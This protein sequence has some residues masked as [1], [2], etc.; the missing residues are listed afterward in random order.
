[1]ADK[2]VTV[3]LEC[4]DNA[5][6]KIEQTG[7]AIDK[8][9]KSAK[10]IDVSS[11]SKASS[12][13]SDLAKW[14][15]AVKFDGLAKV[16]SFASEAAASL[17]KSNSSAE[18][19]AR[20]IAELIKA[21]QLLY[22]ASKQSFVDGL[23]GILNVTGS[24]IDGIVG[25]GRGFLDLTRH[26]TGS[27]V[28]FKGLAKSALDY[29]QC[30]KRIEVKSGTT[31]VKIQELDDTI[32]NI[33]LNTTYST[34]EIAA[35]A[36][37]M[38]QNGQKVTE[39]IDNLYAVTS[40]ATLGNIDLAKSG[41]IVAT[42]MNMFR[43]QSLTATQAANMFAYAANHSGANV[44][45]LA[46]SLENCGPSAA[47]LNVPFSE[48]MAVLGAVGDNAIKSGK[49]GT[50]LKNLLQNMSAPTKNTAKCI[51]ELGLE[52][53]QTAITSGHLID[54]L[55]LIKERLNDGTL[56]AGQQNAAIKALAGAWGSQGLGAV[57]NGSEVELRAMARAMEDGKDST[58]ALEL[59]SGKL[60]DTLEGK[61]YKFSASMEVLAIRIER[62]FQGTFIGIIDHVNDFV[63]IL[64][65]KGPAEAIKWVAQESALHMKDME[66]AV[67]K[68]LENI[69]RLVSDGGMLENILLAGTNIIKS[70]CNGI[71]QAAA[72]GTLQGIVDG[73]IKNICT[74]INNNLPDV[75]EAAKLII[76]AIIK[77][78]KNNE[79]GIREAIGNIG[80]LITTFAGGKAN[81][82]AEF[83]N[84]ADVLMTKFAEK[85][86]EVGIAKVKESIKSIFGGEQTLENSFGGGNP[87]GNAFNPKEG[88]KEILK[89][90]GLTHG[91]VYAAEVGD[92]IEGKQP[93]VTATQ[94]QNDKLQGLMKQYGLTNGTLYIDEVDG[95]LKTGGGKVIATA[96]EIADVSASDIQSALES[97][98]VGQLQA[99]NDA[100]ETLGQTT[101]DTAMDMETAFQRITDS[102]R[103]QFL[104]LANIVRNQ[105]LNVSNIVRNQMVNCSN[106]FR[107]QFVN[108]TNIAK[109][110]MTNV[111]NNIRTSM[112]NACNIVR[113]QCVN[114]T[115]IVKNQFT[116][117][118]NT[119]R[120]QF[121]NMTNIAR[122]QFVNMA[123]VARNQ[124]TNIS[125]IVR[126][127]ATSWSNIMKNQ[128]QNARNALTS[129]F[130]SMA[131][132][133]RTQMTNVSNIIRNQATSWSNII[134]NQ[135]QNA[136]NALTSSF[137]SMAAVARTQMV[138]ISNI[139]RNQAVSWSNIIRNQAQNARN[140]LTRSF[141]S[142]AAVA[143]T[144]MAKVASVVRS[145]MNSI[146]AACSRKLTI[147]VSVKK[148]VT[149]TQKT[150][151]QGPASLSM[152]I[153]RATSLSG[154]TRGIGSDSISLGTLMGAVTASASKGQA[155]NIEVP[156]YLEGRE[157]ARASA[158][159][160][161]GELSRVNT[162]TDRKRGVK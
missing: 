44:E 57:L 53:A 118:T 48:L 39:V 2:R 5:T 159:Y 156:L 162:R 105:M 119:A 116:N 79:G 17:A 85:M 152:A 160:M 56:S 110:Q 40:L 18:L 146:A 49:A 16:S 130:I 96:D 19:A 58:E 115:N 36:E 68:G 136:R 148:T 55:M 6:K 101:I 81:I 78:M 26:V 94:K 129:S 153:P 121:T 35:A 30:L 149:T 52:Q 83:A 31:G 66:N 107:N 82:E 127:Q 61:M 34:S 109:N 95:S 25:V 103:T 86:Y 54:G 125:N 42:T 108:M 104:G 80:D 64:I 158:K 145:Y 142:M 71:K 50:A 1:M 22:Q 89:G 63:N 11:L 138:N 14:S 9:S 99:L 120:S 133:A 12:A 23:K 140:A 20:G 10:G 161:D 141:M 60:M 7:K 59:A 28:S 67:V 27:D 51:K 131:S 93:L 150:V 114:M 75:I 29:E 137:L 102:A 90:F 8:L 41:D 124:M 128:C 21:H 100:M 144:Q 4:V 15:S 92:T 122:N 70:L 84:F 151:K 47:R 32:Q 3:T 132:V 111:A 123:N 87:L 117:M 76:D 135:V 106:I 65:N 33:A 139:M 134:R 126:N 38:I 45:Q 77:G 143:R 112:V 69:K 147:N 37:N 88:I 74:F 62:A 154:M 24:V 73:V 43:N 155:V 97:M 46:K 98:D 13:M 157:I 91:E 113:N 72:N